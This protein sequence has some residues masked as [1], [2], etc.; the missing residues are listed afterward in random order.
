M[1]YQYINSVHS[2]CAYIVLIVLFL[3]TINALAGFFTKKEFTVKDLRLSLFTLIFSH[4]QLLLGLL[5]YAVTPRLMA[6]QM[7]AKIVMKDSL[8]RQLL[9]E[10]P[11]M[12]IIAVTLI[13]IGWVKH[14]KQTTNRGKFGKIAIFYTIALVCLLSMIP[15]RLWWNF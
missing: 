14:K 15:W 7:G 11:L 4:I 6:W 5:L 3:S 10:H 12:N 9:V 2:L 13:T 1:L 8:L